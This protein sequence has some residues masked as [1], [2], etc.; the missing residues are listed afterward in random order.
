MGFPT[1]G[2]G[3]KMSNAECVAF[4][5]GITQDKAD[6][7]FDGDLAIAE[8]SAKEVIDSFDNLSPVRQ[9]VLT[10]MAFELGRGGLSKF[11]K[12]IEAIGDEDF[13]EA[14]KQMI[15]SAYDKEVPRRATENSKLM[16]QG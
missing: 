16:A 4:K 2:Y 1:I 10:D 11:H 6:E 5:G 12:M 15:D 13:T 8:S 9:M 7:L 14:S 3:H